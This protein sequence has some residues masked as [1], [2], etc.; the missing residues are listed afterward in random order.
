MSRKGKK[1]AQRRQRNSGSRCTLCGKTVS[2][3]MGG[4]IRGSTG[5]LVCGSCVRASKQVAPLL[6]HPDAR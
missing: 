4:V 1:R 6:I 3:T 5:Q 2:W